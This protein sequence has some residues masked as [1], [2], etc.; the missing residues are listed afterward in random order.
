MMLEAYIPI[1]ANRKVAVIRLL[2]HILFLYLVT[3]SYLMDHLSLKLVGTVGARN[4]VRSSLSQWVLS[5]SYELC[6]ELALAVGA[7]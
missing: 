2:F 1:A 4:H 7:Q 3:K 5:R 6:E